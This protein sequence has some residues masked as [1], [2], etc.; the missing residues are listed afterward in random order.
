MT[1]KMELILGLLI[2]DPAYSY[3]DL[4]RKMNLSRKTIATY[5]KKLKDLGYIERIGTDRKGYWKIIKK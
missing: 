1:D 3:I 2:E 5:I 4:A